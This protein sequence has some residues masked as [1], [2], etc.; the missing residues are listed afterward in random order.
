MELPKQRAALRRAATHRC[1]PLAGVL[2]CVGAGEKQGQFAATSQGWRGGRGGEPGKGRAP[3]LGSRLEAE[4][5]SALGVV[6]RQAGTCT[7]AALGVKAFL[8]GD[9]HQVLQ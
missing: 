5:V 7:E 1:Q 9:G 4:E 3:K 8:R 6:G 2:A